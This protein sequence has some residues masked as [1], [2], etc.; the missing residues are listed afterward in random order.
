MLELLLQDRAAVE[1]TRIP[2]MQVQPVV[3]PAPRKKARKQPIA[4]KQ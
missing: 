3:M 4:R 1:S 2:V